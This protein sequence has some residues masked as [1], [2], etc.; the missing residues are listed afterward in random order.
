MSEGERIFQN[1]K[2]VQCDASREKFTDLN[3]GQDGVG[4]DANEITSATNLDQQSG[5][6]KEKIMLK[7]SRQVCGRES[8]V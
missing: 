1:G 4:G 8:N 7:R 3:G 6:K 2:L 5:R